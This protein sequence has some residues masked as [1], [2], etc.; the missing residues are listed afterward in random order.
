MPLRTGRRDWLWGAAI[1]VVLLIV[2]A[3]VFLA[4]T[5]EGVTTHAEVAGVK[6]Q[7]KE[8]LDYHIHSS[9]TIM[10]EGEVVP[11][12]DVGRIED[13][14]LFWLHT[15]SN[16][17]RLVHVEA[18]EEQVFTLGQFFQ[19]WG[20]PLSETQLLDRTT[21]AEHEIRATV[22]GEPFAGNPADIPL[23][24]QDSIVLQYGPPFGEPPPSAFDEASES[25]E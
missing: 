15:H 20:Q 13:K 10:I 9:L 14:C 21:D 7:S 5:R 4:L 11:V 18:P 3:A 2:V 24:D 8:R 12:G 1:G 6:C 16:D 25:A 19:V 17:T 23:Q 22:N